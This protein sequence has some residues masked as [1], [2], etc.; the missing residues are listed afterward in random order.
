MSV[1]YLLTSPKP[2]IEGTDAVLQE[3][4]ALGASVGGKMLNLNPRKMP[5]AFF[6]QWLFG[7]HAL[8]SLWSAD[9]T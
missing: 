4:E 2:A 7:F 9:P 5:G 6:P 3:V 1:L 8:P